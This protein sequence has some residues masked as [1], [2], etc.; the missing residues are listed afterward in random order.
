MKILI[1]AYACIPDRG[2]EEGRVW[3]FPWQLAQLGHEV[4]VMTPVDNLVK[5]E[6]VL[7]SQPQPNLH[8]IPVAHPS[9]MS[10]YKHSIVHKY[11]IKNPTEY[12]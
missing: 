1:C 8:V 4:W 12:L 9:W 10:R 6:Q 5:I 11:Q 7:A 2:R 3:N